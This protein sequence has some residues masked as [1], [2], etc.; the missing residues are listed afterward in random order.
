METKFS[1]IVFNGTPT[2]YLAS[3]DGFVYSIKKDGSL[4]KLRQ[5]TDKDGYKK[6]TIYVNK[7]PYE[8][9]VH[10]LVA[11]AFIENPDNKPEVN[12]KDGNKANNHVS[13]L[14]WATC[15]ENIHHA[16]A[17]N[18]STAK[19]C[20]NH[21]N[22]I[23]TREQIESVCELISENNFTMKEIAEK[24][25]VSYTVVKQVK[26]KIIWKNVSDHFDFS[27]FSKSKKT[28]LTD[29]QVANV[30]SYIEAG[31]EL[32]EVSTTLGINRDT[33]QRIH[34]RKIWR[35]ISGNFKW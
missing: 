27:N 19:Y 32:D 18:L 22:S 9:G 14:E 4:L 25:G 24:T 35:R 30:C 33:V 28:M 20:E 2:S 16:W 15:M 11:S 29:F 13:N 1:Q 21:P 7:K 5:K 10:R 8:R 34:D 31:Y 23:Y 17:N 26:N 12:H 6:C 3:D